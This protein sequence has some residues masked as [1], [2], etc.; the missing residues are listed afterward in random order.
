MVA[1]RFSAPTRPTQTKP[2][3]IE[4]G[5]DAAR[6]R[7]DLDHWTLGQVF[8]DGWGEVDAAELPSF[9]PLSRGRPSPHRTARTVASPPLAGTNHGLE[10]VPFSRARALSAGQ[11]PLQADRRISQRSPRLVSSLPGQSAVLAASMWR[12]PRGLSRGP[13]STRA[14]LYSQLSQPCGA[15]SSSEGRAGG[16]LW[17]PLVQNRDAIFEAKNSPGYTSRSLSGRSRPG[18]VFPAMSCASMRRSA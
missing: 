6:H 5:D 17:P 14:R 10:P 4:R 11:A 15:C 2:E 3:G 16:R 12:V 13:L 18:P 9:R 7:A 8:E 1:V